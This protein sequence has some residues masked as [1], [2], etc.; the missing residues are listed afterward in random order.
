MAT[1]ILA[2]GCGA[3]F[4]GDRVDAPARSCARWSS[5]AARR[6]SC[7]RCWPSARWPSRSSRAGRPSAATSRCSIWSC[8]RSCGTASSHH[9]PIVGNFGA[10]N[11]RGAAARSTS[12][13]RARAR[14]AAHRGGRRRRP[15]G[16]SAGGAHPRAPRPVDRQRFVCANVYQGAFP[17]AAAMRGRAGRRHRPRRRSLAGPRAGDGAL[18]LGARTTGTE[19]RPARRWPATCSSAVRR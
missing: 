18:R 19:A 13:R 11:P 2:V 15:V 1:D 12:S 5:A 4:S 9:I 14:R 6:R 3:G 10:A 8:G 7:S 16:R 17:I